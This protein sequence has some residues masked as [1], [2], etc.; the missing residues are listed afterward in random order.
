MSTSPSVSAPLL[1]TEH[2]D[3]SLDYLSYCTIF[4]SFNVR[5]LLQALAAGSCDQSSAS[6]QKLC[7]ALGTWSCDRSAS[8][9]IFNAELFC[10][11]TLRLEFLT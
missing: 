2:N 3:V 9:H 10:R 6:S 8:H 4:K 7:C 5:G 11:A 1:N